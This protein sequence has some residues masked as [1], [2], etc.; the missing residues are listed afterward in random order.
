MVNFRNGSAVINTAPQK[1]FLALCN[2]L[3]LLQTLN[4]ILVSEDAKG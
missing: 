2:I 3:F 4:N 1:L